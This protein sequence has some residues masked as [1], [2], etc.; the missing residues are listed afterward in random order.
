MADKKEQLTETPE[1]LEDKP[2]ETAQ[3]EQKQ[4]PEKTPVPTVEETPVKTEE[5]TATEEVKAE[6]E[7]VVEPN[8][9]EEAKEETP[10]EPKKLDEITKGAKE[11]LHVITEAK[12]ELVA[13]YA[14]YKDITVQKEQLSKDVKGLTKEL[15]ET[16]EQLSKYVEAE[17]EI[18]AKQKTEKLE[19]LSKKFE[20]LGQNKTVEQ[21]SKMDENTL[22]EFEQIV[23]AALVKAGDTAVLPEVTTPSQAAPEAL[24]KEASSEKPV[25]EVPKPEKL[26][27]VRKETNDEFFH[28]MCGTLS[29]EQ[30]KDTHTAKFL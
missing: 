25:V 24:N 28:R 14:K 27:Q 6:P 26:R 9:V 4:E 22:G 3:P 13:L 30:L 18:N 17:K 10:V 29:K 21:L 7:K 5:K 20:L 1:T 16:K 12:N 2:V 19:K 8:K 23:D 11:Q 15:S